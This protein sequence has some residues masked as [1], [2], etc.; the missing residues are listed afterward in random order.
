M[1]TKYRG[2]IIKC[3]ILAA[4]LVCLIALPRHYQSKVGM[5]QREYDDAMA[6]SS[7]EMLYSNSKTERQ[8]AISKANNLYKYKKEGRVEEIKDYTPLLTLIRIGM[9][10]TILWLS[11]VVLRTVYREVDMLNRKKKPEPEESPAGP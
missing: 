4:L 6:K 5:N 3:V 8:V 7:D 2:L 10:L 1:A 9:I 11:W